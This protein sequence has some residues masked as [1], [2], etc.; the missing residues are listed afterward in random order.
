MYESG[1]LKDFIIYEGPGVY[2]VNE[3]YFTITFKSKERPERN[4]ERTKWC[5]QTEREISH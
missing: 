3:V 1:P 4:M 5:K 2:T